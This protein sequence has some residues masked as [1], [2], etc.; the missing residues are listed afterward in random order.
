MRKGEWII[1]NAS[2][3]IFLKSV[4]LGVNENEN[5]HMARSMGL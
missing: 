1:A 4:N 2:E 3:N 5:S